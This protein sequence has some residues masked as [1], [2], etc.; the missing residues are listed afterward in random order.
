MASLKLM[1][2]EKASML[3]PRLVLHSLM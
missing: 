3:N 1:Y 2:C